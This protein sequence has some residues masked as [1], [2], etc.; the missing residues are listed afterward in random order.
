MGN[1][2]SINDLSA[3]AGHMQ[4]LDIRIFMK[5][6]GRREGNVELPVKLLRTWSEETKELIRR[7]ADLEQAIGSIALDK[8][9]A[10]KRENA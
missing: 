1:T 5:T 7:V 9:E 10:K 2:L 4:P 8:L 6:Q 3:A